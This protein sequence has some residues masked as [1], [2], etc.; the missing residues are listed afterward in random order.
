MMS[1]PPIGVGGIGPLAGVGAAA[2]SRP[3]AGFGDALVRGLEQVSASEQR[4]DTLATDMAAGGPTQVTDLMVATTESQLAVDL[5]VQVRNR[6][7]EA[8]QE[9]MRL[10]L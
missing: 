8:Y 1:V 3:A 4:V 2:P 6:A 10:P 5:L 9:V 7:V